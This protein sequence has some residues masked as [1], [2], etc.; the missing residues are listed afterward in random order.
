MRD[1]T[2][3]T[4]ERARAVTD[5][6]TLANSAI[7]LATHEVRDRARIDRTFEDDV[8]AN[9]RG[10]RVAQVVLNLVVNAA[11]AIRPGQVD[12]NRIDVRVF[13]DREHACVAVSD[14]GSGVPKEIEQRIFEPFFTTREACG[15]TGLGLWLSRAIV[16]EEGGTLTYAPRAGG[17]ACFTVTLPLAH[18]AV[19]AAAAR[20]AANP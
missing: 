14:T 16:E 4:R 15:G 8:T 1:M 11:Q 20:A 3:F 9:V 7:R 2:G 6:T 10:A 18:V 5:L 19:A 13:K 17:G 12:A